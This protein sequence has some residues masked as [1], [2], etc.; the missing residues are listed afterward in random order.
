MQNIAHSSPQLL[1]YTFCRQG[2]V[3]WIYDLFIRTRTGRKRRG[4]RGLDKANMYT[5]HPPAIVVLHQ[6]QHLMALRAAGT[7]GDIVQCPPW[8][9]HCTR[10]QVLDMKLSMG[11]QLNV[12]LIEAIAP[13]P[14]PRSEH[15]NQSKTHS[16]TS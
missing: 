11:L 8:C 2:N 5:F 7:H 3:L 15:K 1:S 12:R 10:A 16:A 9:E 14:S 6:L 13:S 4:G